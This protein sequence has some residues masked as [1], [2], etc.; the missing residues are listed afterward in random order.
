MT[1]WEAGVLMI[2]R[3]PETQFVVDGIL[4][5]AHDLRIKSEV[6]HDSLGLELAT[7]AAS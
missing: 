5:H 1:N 7:S 6:I 3:T 4:A 2:A